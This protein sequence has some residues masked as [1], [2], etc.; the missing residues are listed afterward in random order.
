MT[1]LKELRKRANLT[2]HE[3]ADLLNISRP[4]YCLIENNKKKP[5][6]GLAKKIGLMFNIPWYQFIINDLDLQVEKSTNIV[7]L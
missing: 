1:S 2:Q 5:S 4:Y 3:T 6:I 7:N